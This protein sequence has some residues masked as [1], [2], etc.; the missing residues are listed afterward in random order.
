MVDKLRYKPLRSLRCRPS[1]YLLIDDLIKHLVESHHAKVVRLD[2]G[3]IEKSQL[4]CFVVVV[5][6][7]LLHCFRQVTST[8][9]AWQPIKHLCKISSATGCSRLSK[10]NCDLVDSVRWTHRSHWLL[11]EQQWPTSRHRSKPGVSSLSVGFLTYLFQFQNLPTR[12]ES[13][14]CVHLRTKQC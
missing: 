10:Y 13:K 6:F 1:G 4:A 7:W 14:H 9:R 11:P 12:R 3:V 8:S 5:H 2:S